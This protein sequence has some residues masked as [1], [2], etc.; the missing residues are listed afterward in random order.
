MFLFLF[1]SSIFHL[2]FLSSH[3]I[4]LTTLFPYL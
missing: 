2:S 4:F 3:L 1:S